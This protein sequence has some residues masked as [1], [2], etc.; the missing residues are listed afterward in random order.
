MRRHLFIH[1]AHY[2]RSIL[3]FRY[4]LQVNILFPVELIDPFQSFLLPLAV[5]VFITEHLTV[6]RLRI[7]NRIPLLRLRHVQDLFAFLYRKLHILLYIAS[8]CRVS[9]ARFFA[10]LS[11]AAA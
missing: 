3:G 2:L 5:P 10:A 7:Q 4:L 11:P 9:L 8:F 1:T 6:F